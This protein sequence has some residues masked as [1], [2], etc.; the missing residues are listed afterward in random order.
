MP[1]RSIS[2]GWSGN[3]ARDLE[4]EDWELDENHAKAALRLLKRRPAADV[5]TVRIG[6]PAAGEWTS[7]FAATIDD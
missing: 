5:F 7:I 3:R 2:C 1:I 4:T 6:Y